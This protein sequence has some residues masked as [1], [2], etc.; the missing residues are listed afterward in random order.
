MK[1]RSL[2]YLFKEGVKNIWSNRTM[3]IASVGVLV[4]CLLL[5][6]AAV[7]FSYNINSA[8]KTIEGNNSVR[9]YM[10]QDLPTLSAIKVGEEI[11]KLDNIKT[12]EFVPKDEAIQQYMKI[13][14]DKNGTM[15][16]GMTGKDNPL[17]DAFKVSFKDLS[18]YKDTA[19][20]I[21]KIPGV[22]TINDYS[23]VAAKLT[24]LDKVVTMAGFWIILLLS[25]VSLFI[26][27]N[28]IRVT[29]FSRRVEISIMKSVGATN[30]FIRVPF[31]VEG[32]IIGMLSGALSSFLLFLIYD[33]MVG[34]ITSITLFSPVDISPMAGKILLAFMLAGTLFGAVGG[35][36]SIS[37]YLKKEGGEIVGW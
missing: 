7:V 10:T 5:T 19:A 8:M 33:K 23:D 1:I 36:I 22:A 17:P 9:I 20:Q 28:T 16:Q 21:K 34:S 35:V 6:G 29:M 3:S 37:K 31:I 24:R 30:G 25:L 4:S 27:S 11:K 18:K 15:L 2:G 14:G 26:I 12:C 32:I 13:L